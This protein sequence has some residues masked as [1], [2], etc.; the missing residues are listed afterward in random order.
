MQAPRLDSRCSRCIAHVCH[1]I[2][3]PAMMFAANLEHLFGISLLQ[4][5]LQL[6]PLPRREVGEHGG[7]GTALQLATR[8]VHGG[9][10]GSGRERKALLC[11]HRRLPGLLRVASAH[12]TD[13]TSGANLGIDRTASRSHHVTTNPAGDEAAWL[14]GTL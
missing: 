2:I 1:E 11:V 12:V 9:R 4:Q 6:L 3:E 5:L 7:D 8:L 14:M 13:H 10:T